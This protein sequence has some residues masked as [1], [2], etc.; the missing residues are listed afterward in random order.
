MGNSS[1]TGRGHQ[2]ETVD[3][4]FLTPQVYTGQRDWNQAV[5]A[6]AIVERRLAPFYRPLEDYEESWDEEQIMAARKE[7]PPELAEGAG[8]GSSG[9]AHRAES[10][11]SRTHGKRSSHSGKEPSRHPE[12]AIYRGAVECP[13]CFLYYPPNINYSRCCEQP[14]CT[15]CFV[16]IKRAE[17]TPQHLESEPAACPYCVQENFG[18]VYTPPKWR[19][20]IGSEGAM[21]PSPGMQVSPSNPP[22]TRRRKSFGANDPEVVTIDYIRPDW[23]QKLAAVKA[24]VARR[25]ARRIIMRQVGDRLI[26][27]GVTS[28]RVHLL[29]EGA[30]GALGQGDGEGGGGSSGGRRS[31]RRGQGNPGLGEFL[32][33]GGQDIEELMIMEAMRLSLIEEEER[34]RKEREKKAKEEAEQAKNGASAAASASTSA[35]ESSAAT[36]APRA[37]TSNLP[38]L[39]IPGTSAS[40]SGRTS[41][42]ATEERRRSLTPTETTPA[43]GKRHRFSA[44]LSRLR[45]RSPSPPRGSS[46]SAAFRNVGATAAAVGTPSPAS[47]RA[48]GGS[49]TQT[50]RASAPGTATPTEES[51][52][53]ALSVPVVVAPDADA[54]GSGSS[55]PATAD[56]G[57][58]V[59]A[60]P[61]PVHAE[62]FASS[63]ASVDSARAETYDRLGS[64]DEGESVARVPLLGADTVESPTSG[65]GPSAR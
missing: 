11:N 35:G 21:P 49:G 12:A 41:L 51:A 26:P 23:E 61:R 46:V 8:E 57:L 2:E 25:A 55:A 18:V 28:G 13:I 31:R 39:T 30:E 4:G 54:E 44:S 6:Q 64:D 20:G 43:S 3:F 58:P 56:A 37:G 16:Q 32:G 48:P 42:D 60:P 29:P 7:P 19:A 52:G 22:P 65:L 27:V 15:E 33:L 47:E 53:A 24:A 59:P 14:I 38:T 40:S 62:S 17:P 63:V 10:V 36:T 50:P 34:Q 1:S 45:G 5:V 9:H